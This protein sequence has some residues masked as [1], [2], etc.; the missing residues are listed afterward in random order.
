MTTTEAATTACERELAKLKQQRDELRAKLHAAVSM[1]DKH[2]V[3]QRKAILAGDDPGATTANGEIV[4]HETLS[5]GLQGALDEL[6]AQISVCEGRQIDLRDRAAREGETAAVKAAAE[7]T[8]RAALKFQAAAAE[9]TAAIGRI[10]QRS[11]ELAGLATL[12]QQVATEVPA[13]MTAAVADLQSYTRGLRA[14]IEEPRVKLAGLRPKPQAA[15]PPPPP[16][17]APSGV[18]YAPPPGWQP[19]H[20]GF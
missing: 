5:A 2:R 18:K 8:E 6:T 17:S 13:T 1:T 16:P 20:R 9:L 14:G 4:K 10:G 12:V 11:P 7:E 19:P 15:P 3:T